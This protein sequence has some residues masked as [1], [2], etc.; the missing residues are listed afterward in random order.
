MAVR[1][2]TLDLCVFGCFKGNC[3]GK[4]SPPE[5]LSFPNVFTVLSL[6]IINT[7]GKGNKTHSKQIG[8]ELLLF[9][10]DRLLGRQCYSVIYSLLISFAMDCWREG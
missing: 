2:Q 1:E 5:V 3:K 7:I 6:T 10:I 9:V 4:S 8:N